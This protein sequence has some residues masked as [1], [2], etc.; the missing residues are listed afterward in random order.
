MEIYFFKKLYGKMLFFAT[1]LL[2]SQ[3]SL[4]PE[5]PEAQ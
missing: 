5:E 2:F 4:S 1:S 3:R